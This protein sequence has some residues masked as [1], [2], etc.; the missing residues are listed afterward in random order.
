M[1]H[2]IAFAAGSIAALAIASQASAHVSLVKA[3]PAVNAAAASPSKIQLQF[4]GKIETKFSGFDV[5]KADGSKVPIK[6]DAAAPDG[7]TLSAKVGQKLAPGAYKVAWRIVST[8]GH[9]MTGGYNFTV[10]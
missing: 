5:L 9:R 3:T 7:R 2:A 10:R 1:R 6:A 8:D 4:S